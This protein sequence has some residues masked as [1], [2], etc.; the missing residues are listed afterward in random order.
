MSVFCS[1]NF[2]S[3][4]NVTNAKFAG[5]Y[6]RHIYRRY[7]H[8]LRTH[9]VFDSAKSANEK[10]FVEM[11]FM[12]G[13][14]FCRIYRDITRRSFSFLYLCCLREARENPATPFENK[15]TIHQYGSQAQIQVC[16]ALH[17]SLST[18]NTA[19]TERLFVLL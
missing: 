3:A 14:I 10:I 19:I 7:R 11:R 18:T 5:N 4:L 2:F 17:G 9:C 6:A 16:K 12:A 15:N 1:F 13:S 8:K